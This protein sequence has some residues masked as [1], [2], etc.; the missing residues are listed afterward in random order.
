MRVILKK[1]E[2]GIKHKK[3]ETMQFRLLYE[4]F[5]IVF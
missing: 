2:A 4:N 1:A 3:A 5:V